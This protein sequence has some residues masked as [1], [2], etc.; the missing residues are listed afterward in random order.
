LTNSRKMNCTVPDFYL[1]VDRPSE[2]APCRCEHKGGGLLS[3]FRPELTSSSYV[4]K[5]YLESE[6]NLSLSC[7]LDV[8][9]RTLEHVRKRR[10][11][12]QD[13]VEIREY[14]ITIGDHPCCSSGLPLTLDWFHAE[15]PKYLSMEGSCRERKSRYKS[16]RR[17]S[18][19][20]RRDRLFEVSV[21]GEEKVRGEEVEMVMDFLA[22][23]WAQHKILPPPEFEDL[24]ELEEEEYVKPAKEQEVS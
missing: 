11:S 6:D 1:W 9:S 16:P 7:K 2:E 22:I 24:E 19:D 4:E 21:N 23:S 5:S 20:Q 14:S 10:V 13:R 18:Y 3:F 15:E 12:F 17:L 8:C